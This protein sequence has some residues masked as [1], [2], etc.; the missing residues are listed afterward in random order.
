MA[1][2]DKFAMDLATDLEKQ[3][4]LNSDNATIAIKMDNIGEFESHWLGDSL[5]KKMKRLL[6]ISYSE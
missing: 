4:S 5:L 3:G 1:F 2:L 6:L